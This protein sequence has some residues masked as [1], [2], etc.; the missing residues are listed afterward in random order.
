MLDAVKRV[1][2]DIFSGFMTQIEDYDPT[3]AKKLQSLAKN[4]N[5]ESILEI[6]GRKI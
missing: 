6:L 3:L 5:Y 2:F 1:R 4:Y